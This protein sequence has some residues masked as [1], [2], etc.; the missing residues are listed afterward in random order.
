MYNND[1]MSVLLAA[2]ES[3][4]KA[5]LGIGD[6]DDFDASIEISAMESFVDDTLNGYST[7]CES[8]FDR[9]RYSWERAMESDADSSASADKPKA[10]IWKTITNAV[11]AL[12]EKIGKLFQKAA[13]G[14]RKFCAKVKEKL[15]KPKKLPASASRNANDARLRKSVSDYMDSLSELT[16]VSLTPLRAAHTI[17]NNFKRY[18]ANSGY[19]TNFE[20][21]G[22]ENDYSKCEEDA[23]LLAG[24][25][26]KAKAAKSTFDEAA[27]PYK[28]SGVDVISIIDSTCHDELGGLISRMDKMANICQENKVFADAFAKLY[29]SYHGTGMGASYQATD[30]G[31]GTDK[32]IQLSDN[33]TEAQ[34]YKA[35]KQY[36]KIAGMINQAQMIVTAASGDVG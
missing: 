31:D 6:L 5:Q 14:F 36:L 10:G 20:Y 16:T 13:E 30:K 22:F 8:T 33:N 4:L 18:L 28:T 7:A 27:S 21:A 34:M 9:C 26:N 24:A 2:E 1:L 12:L 19:S 3:L 17:M 25:I 32:V 15:I 11:K 29:D 35:A 23:G